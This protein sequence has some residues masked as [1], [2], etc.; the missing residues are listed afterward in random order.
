M[1]TARPSSSPP[2]R[3][4][5]RCLPPIA[6]ACNESSRRCPACRAHGALA[7]TD[8]CDPRRASRR[9]AVA[10]GGPGRRGGHHRHGDRRV[11]GRCCCVAAALSLTIIGGLMVAGGQLDLPVITVT[12]PSNTVEH[13]P[14]PA[15]SGPLAPTGGARGRRHG[16]R[17]VAGRRGPRE[18]AGSGREP[19]GGQRRHGPAPG[20]GRGA[21][22]DRRDGLVS[23]DRRQPGRL[24]GRARSRRAAA[25][26]RRWS[27]GT[28][29]PWSPRRTATS[30]CAWPARPASSAGPSTSRRSPMRAT[31]AGPRT[32]PRL[33]FS[34]RP[35]GDGVARAVYLV[36]ADGTGLRRAGVGQRGRALAALEPGGRSA[37]RHP[38][39]PV[40]SRR[41]GQST[42]ATGGAWTVV[43]EGNAPSW[44]ADGRRLA[45]LRGPTDGRYRLSIIEADGS[46]RDLTDAV[47]PLSRVSW[48]P[49]R[50]DDRHDRVLRERLRDLRRGR[51]VRSDRP[52]HRRRP[53]L[54]D[55]GPR[56]APAWPCRPAGRAQH[57]VAV[58]SLDGS[59]T[60]LASGAVSPPGGAVVAGRSLDR[61]R[62][63]RRRIATD[64]P[65]ARRTASAPTPLPGAR[66]GELTVSWRPVLV[67]GPG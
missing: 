43:G 33:A 55:A 35:V 64:A 15:P 20:R 32:G 8:R 34:A 3:S 58:L 59:V 28:S 38:P 57:V 45:V 41:R 29:R 31:R 10:R 17:G 24:G 49:G 27:Q 18:P 26:W 7:G 63:G 11:R 50:H 12:R 21:A 40:R 44:S 1:T 52:G 13:A 30:G 42:R 60:T 46:Q 66:A 23:T 14:V 19:P 53:R 16:G 56:T 25:S 39:G 47:F 5:G 62:R 22:S 9:P 51:R 67:T 37:R 65:R 4:I 36:D 48:S 54:P 2:P 61:R 6:T